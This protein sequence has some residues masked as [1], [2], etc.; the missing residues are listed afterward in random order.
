MVEHEQRSKTPKPFVYFW[1]SVQHG[2]KKA[3]KERAN[4]ILKPI[5][6]HHRQA[7]KIMEIGC[8]IGL[9]LANLPKR[10][11]IYG[12]DVEKDYIEFVGRKSPEE[13][14]SF[15]V[16]TASKSPRS[17]TSYFLLMTQSIS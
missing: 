5:N 15:P 7:K 14:S 16:C 12:L 17:L 4:Y 1:E 2:G 6:E 13:N 11:L 10:Y 8:G 9:L 3:A